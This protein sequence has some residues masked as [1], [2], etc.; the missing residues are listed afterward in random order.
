M[1]YIINKINLIA[2]K[3]FIYENINKSFNYNFI[4]T[5]L[6]S[7]FRLIQ[8]YLFTNF[9]SPSE[10]ALWIVIFSLTSFY[11]VMDFGINAFL[12][13]HLI[14]INLDIDRKKFLKFV[15][16]GKL[17]ILLSVVFFLFLFVSFLF[18]VD[19]SKI[20]DLKDNQ[21][22]KFIFVS[23]VMLI[24]ISI[25]SYQGL[26]FAI[27]RSIERMH[28][29]LRINI[30][31]IFLQIILFVCFSFFGNIYLI[32]ISLSLPYVIGYIL[33]RIKISEYFN[34]KEIK[35]SYTKDYKNYYFLFTGSISFLI[36]SLS[37]SLLNFIPIYILKKNFEDNLLIDFFIYKSFFLIGLQISNIFNHSFSP[38][39]NYLFNFD[40]KNF[41]II[42][43][44]LL[45]IYFYIFIIFVVISSI[46]GKYIF[47][48]WTNNTVYFDHYL[49]YFFTLFLFLRLSWW[50][51]INIYQ[52][53]NFVKITGL[54]Y[55]LFNLFIFVF[56][57]FFIVPENFILTLKVLF[58]LEILM[59]FLLLSVYS[60]YLGKFKFANYIIIIGNVIILPLLY[61]I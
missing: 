54:L 17:I 33:Y 26:F 13:N 29:A 2:K 6:N 12:S 56:M 42:L 5:A 44:K 37:H 52:S 36:I 51:F 1:N 40:K 3:I 60:Y 43:N 30:Y 9:F 41:E 31:V 53:L 32:S 49:F 45:N 27:L 4:I 47:Y 34:S 15:G 55:F 50:Y 16:L 61:V 19:L 59:L 22:N 39:I 21:V 8:V 58:G 23:L 28:E 24:G 46:F 35:I 18:I 11:F 57:E 7:L 14:K 25:N 48:V 10:Y 20:F 38:K